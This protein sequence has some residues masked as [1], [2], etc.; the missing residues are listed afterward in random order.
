MRSRKQL[1]LIGLFPTLVDIFLL[2]YYLTK[3]TT[4]SPQIHGVFISFL[5]NYDFWSSVV[6]G[7]DISCHIPLSSWASFVNRKELVS[8]SLPTVF[9]FVALDFGRSSWQ[10][11]ITQANIIIFID[12]DVVWLYVAVHNVSFMEKI[13]GTENFKYDCNS[14]VLRESSIL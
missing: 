4:N 13:N 2:L 6:S 7:R 10:P 1:N 12:Q 3:D 14:L 11:K 9:F 8:Q 5:T